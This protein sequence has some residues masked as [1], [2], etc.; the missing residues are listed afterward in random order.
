MKLLRKTIPSNFNL[1]LFGDDHEGSV[2][3][4]QKL[5]NKLC[6]MM[7][8]EY[9]GLTE[10]KNFGVDH[11]DIVEA[12]MIDDPR[13]DPDTVKE[14][15]PLLQLERA[16]KHR[17]CIKEKIITILEG[18]HPLKL[19]K[20]GPLTKMVCE[21][22]GIPYGTWTTKITFID[23]N[24]K[25]LFK[26]FATHGRKSITSTADDPRRRRSNKELTLKRQLKFKAG[27][28]AL[29]SKGHTHQILICRPEQELFLIDDGK[30]IKQ[31]YT[32]WGH[33]ESYIHP[34]A[35]WYVNSGSFLALYGEN[36]SGYAEIA[37]YDPIEIGFVVALVRDK[38]IQ[39]I[40]KVIL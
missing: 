27:D 26:H 21:K 4:S 33:T 30:R 22:L 38:K 5:W 10:D 13:Y 9:E 24:E 6:N 35:R 32:S 28:A 34:D 8:G 15:F 12:I 11:G 36:I 20:F 37:E 19:W 39:D 25:L 40:K 23:K 3:R 29:M 31:D 1:F 17:E 16:V 7:L 2:L 14:P 18:N